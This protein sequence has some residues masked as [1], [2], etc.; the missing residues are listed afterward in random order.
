[1]LY[2]TLSASVSLDHSLKCIV[3]A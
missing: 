1:M 2:V 3:E